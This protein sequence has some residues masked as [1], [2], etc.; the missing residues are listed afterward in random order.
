M[1]LVVG[2]YVR[3]AYADEEM[4]ENKIGYY[5]LLFAADISTNVSTLPAGS[6]INSGE[7]GPTGPRLYAVH[8][9]LSS[10]PITGNSEY[11]FQ[12]TDETATP[13][14]GQWVLIDGQTTMFSSLPAS[15]VRVNPDNVAIWH[16]Y[17]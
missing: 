5:R 10:S 4:D 13:V 3:Q 17:A 2:D 15:S 11:R 14:P 16:R 9:I 12:T 6:T 1:C 7:P 8:R